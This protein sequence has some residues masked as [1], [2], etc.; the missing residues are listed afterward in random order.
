MNIPHPAWI[1]IDLNQFKKNLQSVRCMI[2]NRLLCLCVKADAYGHGLC[3]IGKIAEEE[4]VYSLAVACLKEG[5]ALRKSGIKIPIIILGAIFADQIQD[6]IEWDLE[7]TISSR[8]K[9]NL[10]LDACL[11]LN[12]QAKVHLEV[13]TGL[14]RTG[15]RL[16]TAIEMLPWILGQKFLQLIGVYSHFASSDQ[17]NDPITLEQ[18]RKF[19]VLKET[20]KDEKIIWHLA[21]SGGV[22]NYPQAHLD[23]VRVGLLCY[24]YGNSL[25]SSCFSVKAKVSYFKVVEAGEGISYGHTYKTA[26]KTRIVTVPVGYGDGYMRA[27]SNR[28]IVIIRGK[29]YTISGIVCM[30]QF[31]VD[32]GND[33]VYIEDEVT[34][35]GKQGKEAITVEDAAKIAGTVPYELLCSFNARLSRIYI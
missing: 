35:L 18:I 1:E 16:E 11:R 17:P 28:G 27:F 29:K 23:M 6:I 15:V 13:D 14:H 3:E 10:I 8:F 19:Q 2:G 25:V 9:A 31:M 26:D 21:N 20:F 4:G 30:D 33:D 7:C 24:G 5:I 12:R 34:L 32:I 22:L